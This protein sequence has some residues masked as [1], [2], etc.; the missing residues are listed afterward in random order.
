MMN[1]LPWQSLPILMNCK[2]PLANAQPGRTVLRWFFSTGSSATACYTTATAL[3][4]CP[5]ERRQRCSSPRGL[6]ALCT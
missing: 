2:L 4:T 5:Q 6:C 1:S 3:C